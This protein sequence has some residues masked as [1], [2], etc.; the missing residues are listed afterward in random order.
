[1]FD[2][3]LVRARRRSF[4]ITVSQGG[5][6]EVRV[7]YY[8]SER[9]AREF[10]NSKSE[11]VEK[12][13]KKNADCIFPPKVERGA[14]FFIA[15]KPYVLYF[16]SGRKPALKGENY[17]LIKLPQNFETGAEPADEKYLL[18]DGKRAATEKANVEAKSSNVSAERAN[19]AA[20]EQQIKNKLFLKAAAKIFLPYVKMRTREIANFLGYE[21]KSVRVGYAKTRWGS[22]GG[23]NSI[24]YSVYLGLLPQELIDYVI[25]HELTHTKVKNHGRDFW[26]LVCGAMPN[27]KEKREK[28]KKYSPY[29]SI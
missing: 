27:A 3:V 1:M 22:C 7:P 4:C 14:E 6:V 29:L 15:G 21:Y 10:V 23:D 28:L 18:T 25:L 2:Y 11:W 9:A 24:I 17:L 20:G 12:C 8:A 19:V 13:L 5:K 16:Y 26:R